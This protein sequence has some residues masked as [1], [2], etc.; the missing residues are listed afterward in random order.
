MNESIVVQ[1]DVPVVGQYDVVVC[2]GGPA[3]FV[4]AVSAARAGLC[5]AIVERLS[6]F[7]G[8]ATAGYVVP[9]SG[10]FHKG[11]PVVGGIAWEVVQRLVAMGAAQ[12]EHPKG[13]VSVNVECYKLIAQRMLLES[14]VTIYSNSWLSGC[15]KAHGRIRNVII[16]SKNGTEVLQAR[17]FIDATG[18]G[19]LCRMANVPMQKLESPMQPLSM[20]FVLDGVDVNT[21][22]LKEYI[23]HDGQYGHGSCQKQIHDY[24]QFCVE[25]GK[26]RRFGGPWFNTLLDGTA[27][28]VNV[29]RCEGDGAD[30]GDMTRIECQLREDMFTIV[31]LLKNRYPEF[32]DAAIVASGVNA[33]IRETRHIDGVE[34]VTGEFLQSGVRPA[35]AVARCAH[36]MD[37][38]QSDSTQQQLITLVNAG[39]I[40]HKALIPRT[41][42]NLIAAGRC[43]SADAAAYAS[44]RVQATLMAVGE[45]AGL[46]AAQTLKNRNT[47]V[48]I[49]IEALNA[50]IARRGIVR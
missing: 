41:V 38:H 20:C 30:R 31:A 12:V 3:G 39:Y 47:V 27:L 13:N 6:F 17:C 9:I 45:S 22:L 40:P 37:I 34:T 11:H 43:I 48:N 28:A 35:C 7:G 50:D 24:L 29:T 46:M 49:D 36:P 16:E 5:T 21:P 4:A 1:K 14:G 15:Q 42:D 2:G 19:D 10:F 8:T 33:G 26:L 25:Q 18:D 32:K 44:L 23:H